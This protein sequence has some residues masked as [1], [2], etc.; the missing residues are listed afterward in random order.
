MF[1]TANTY[2]PAEAPIKDAKS[3]LVVGNLHK[4]LDIS[5]V[6]RAHHS[7]GVGVDLVDASG[8]DL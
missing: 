6:I 4:A 8:G 1:S 3:S 2:Q 5:I 7:V